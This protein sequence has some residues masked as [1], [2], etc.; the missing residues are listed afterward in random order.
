M[1]IVCGCVWKM[2]WLLGAYN[3]YSVWLCMEDEVVARALQC[4]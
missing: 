4:I 1:Y 2:R 3:V